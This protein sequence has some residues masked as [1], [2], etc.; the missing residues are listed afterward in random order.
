MNQDRPA[1]Y[2]EMAAKSVNK[3]AVTAAVDKFK[4]SLAEDE[5]IAELEE[6]LRNQLIKVQHESQLAVIKQHIPCELDISQNDQEKWVWH[7]RCTTALDF[8]GVE[9]FDSPLEALAHF[10]AGQMDAMD[11]LLAD[12]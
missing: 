3:E 9:G 5:K 10:T 1:G 8:A 11:D 6:Q 7:Y 12:E 2:E 4:S